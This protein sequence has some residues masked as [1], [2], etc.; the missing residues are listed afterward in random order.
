MKGMLIIR[1]TRSLVWVVLSCVCVVAL[2]VSVVVYQ[3]AQRTA[4]LPG[5]VGPTPAPSAAGGAGTVP[6]ATPEEQFGQEP[7]D[8]DVL[9]LWA[10]AGTQGDFSTA[11]LYMDENNVRTADWEHQHGGLVGGIRDYHISNIEVR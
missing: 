9:H 11:R 8:E 6:S 7:S 5:R 4:E 10:K 2:G 3:R 1:T